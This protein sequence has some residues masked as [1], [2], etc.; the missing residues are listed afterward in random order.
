MK[1]LVKIF[2]LMVVT[3]LVAGCNKNDDFCEVNSSDNQLKS[4]SSRTINFQMTGEYYTP[5]ICDGETVDFLYLSEVADQKTH[6]TAH[7][8]NGQ[9]VWM[10]VHCKLTITSELTGETFKINDQTK[11]T[12]DENGVYDT[13]T[14]HIHS[15][16]DKGTHV[17]MFFE[18][19]WENQT[20]NLFK[21]I[22]PQY[23][24]E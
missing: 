3:S 17:I 20:L 2:F 18:A 5:V 10:I 15:K 9:F 8:K 14:M 12:F 23:G 16:G 21:G 19:D 22:C 24:D 1:T 11:V 13:F 4:A 6:I 7:L